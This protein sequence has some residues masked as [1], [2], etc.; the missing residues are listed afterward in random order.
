HTPLFQVM[1]AMQNAP[2][3]EMAL[4]GLNISQVEV[5]TGTAKFDLILFVRETEEGL[6]GSWEYNTDALD[7]ASVRRM[8]AHFET[9]LRGVVAD[10]SCSLSALPLLPAEEERRLLVEW[11]DTAAVYPRGECLHEMFEAQARLTPNAIAL[12]FEH[13]RWTYRELNRRA[14][15][16][17]HHLRARGVGPESLVGILMERT[18]ELL[19]ALLG[20]L[21]AGAAYVPLDP[22]YP[23]SRLAFMLSD[24]RAPVLLTQERLLG[25]MP[26][27]HAAHVICL[28]TGWEE[29]AGNSEADPA[30]GA[31]SRNLAYLIY[32]SGSTGRPKGVAIEHASAVTLLHWAHENFDAE[33]LR[34]VLASTSVCFDLSIFEIFVPLS[35]GATVILAANALALAELPAADQVTLVNTVPSAMAELVRTRAIPDSVQTVNLAGEALQNALA[36][37]IYEESGVGRVYNLYGPSED[38][39]YSTWTLVERGGEGVPT[40]GRPVSNT[41]VYLLDDA[42]RL[43]PQGVAGELYVG[44]EGLARGYFGRPE[45]TAERFVPDPFSREPG[46]RLYR[47]GDLARYRSDGQIEFL[48]RRDHQVKVRGFRIELGE[49]EAALGEQ[50]EIEE[51]VVVAHRL[52]D[53]EPRLVSYIVTRPGLTPTPGELRQRLKE[54]LPEYMIPSAFVILDEMPLTPNGK[55]NR[56]ALPEPEGARPEM[57]NAYLAPRTP[58]EEELADIWANLLGLRRVGVSDNFFDLGGHSLLATQVVSRVREVF[59]MEMSVRALFEAPTVAELAARIAMTLRTEEVIAPADDAG[60]ER[61]APLQAN[62]YEGEELVERVELFRQAAQEFVAPPILPV[63]RGGALPLSFAQQ[64]L[65]FLH[66]LAPES[67]AYNILGGMRLQGALKVEAFES[68]LNEIVNRHESL[69]TTFTTVDGQPVQVVSAA[70]PIS[71]TLSDLRVLAADERSAQVEEAAYEELK[72]PFDL[73]RGPLLRASLLRLDDDEH[74]ALVTM[75]HIVSDGWSTTLLIK[76]F[77]TLYEAAREGRAHSLAPLPIQYADYAHW[78]RAWLQGEVLDAQLAYWKRALGG[79]LPVLELSTDRPRPEEPTLRGAKL[80]FTLPPGLYRK[81]VA[82]SR[83]AGA[84]LYMTLLAA[85]KT[86][87]Y[88]LTHQDDLIVGTAIAGRNR[89]ETEDL[90]GVFINMLALR[91]DLSGNPS[92]LEL[93]GRVQEVTLAAYAHQDMPFEKLVEELQ[94][95]RALT[96]APLFQIAFG[97]QH[98]PARS[99]ALPGLKL[100]RLSFDADIS[101]YDLT[102]WMFESEGALTASWTYSL[103]LF[104]PETIRRMQGRFETLLRGIVANPEARLS[105][106]EILSEE[107]R[108]LAAAR[109]SEWEESNALK[110]KSVKRRAVRKTSGGAS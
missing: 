100:S 78:Q 93:L 73:E 82:L 29:I 48:G 102:L 16:L 43:V 27:G 42:M 63:P 58:V 103:D 105:E 31:S 80:L 23:P 66:Q 14:N 110:L 2:L 15:Q 69:R 18:T 8:A 77:V 34:G 56:A 53:S 62:V 90:I 33:E 64:R 75:H 55:V 45:L 44:G 20:V 70:Q 52:G 107:E 68:A 4:R 91:T 60:D 40:I 109:A 98:E 21:K 72:R 83:R 84:T 57:E 92:F 38:T 94:P 24:T 32:T 25:Q 30:G 101:R 41:R 81:L 50:P 49:V 17:A 108:R 28:D 12:L 85:F 87:L 96:R 99:F 65:W 104:E 97:L 86:L 39:T 9:L 35:C 67:S 51:A 7:P 13:E 76:E 26:E 59:G 106:F 61:A 6:I 22:N 95:A 54:Q 79:S 1:L 88:R 46:A 74:V 19:V 11:N 36:Q 89:A 10:P 47:T 71:I 37:S 5:D 3:P